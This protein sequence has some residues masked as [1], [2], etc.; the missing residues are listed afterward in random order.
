[1]PFRPGLSPRVRGN[2]SDGVAGP[3]MAGSI[4]ACAG[5]PLAEVS[6]TAQSGVY[7]RVCGGTHCPAQ[8]FPPVQ[9]L[10]PRV[11][12]NPYPTVRR[13][14]LDGSIPAC[15]GEPPAADNCRL[16]GEV[17]PRV[18]G[19][20]TARS[21]LVG[22]GWGLSPRVR[23]NRRRSCSVRASFGSIPACAGEPLASGCADIVR[24]VYPR[25]CGGTGWRCGCACGVGGL[26]PRVRGNQLAGFPYDRNERSIPACAGEPRRGWCWRVRWR[27]YPRVCGGTALTMLS[28]TGMPGLSPR[29]RGNLSPPT[30]HQQPEG[31]IP[32]CAGEPRIGADGKAPNRVYPRVCG[33]TA[34]MNSSPVAAAGLS[35][36]VRG[37][38]SQAVW[39]WRRWGSIPACAGE[40][41]VETQKALVRRVYPRVCG[42]TQPTAL[43]VGDGFGLSPRVRG[44]PRGHQAVLPRVRSIPA[45]AGEPATGPRARY[46]GRVYPRV[47]GGTRRNDI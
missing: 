39:R 30:D 12:G 13:Q 26:S 17:Y 44:N 31:S 20:T 46:S 22:V 15:A 36:R 32:A 7:P 34:A 35:P 45:C 21:A 42:G 38:P 33:G 5:E 27:V 40:P 11:R 10:S 25:V 47:C 4:P 16:R 37:N 14:Q 28:P 43:R 29:V 1:M 23:G 2:R 8:P 19:G 9:G 3:G 18:C 24:E 41:R 6:G